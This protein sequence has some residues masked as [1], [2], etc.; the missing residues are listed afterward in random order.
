MATGVFEIRFI[1]AE[2]TSEEV[3]KET[4]RE[5]ASFTKDANNIA[6]FNKFKNGVSEELERL[7]SPSISKLSSLFENENNVIGLEKASCIL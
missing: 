4:K 3:R 5:I 6:E 7:L 1:A 2:R